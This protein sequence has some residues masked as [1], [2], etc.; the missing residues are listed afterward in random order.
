MADYCMKQKVHTKQLIAKHETMAPFLK[1]LTDFKNKDKRDNSKQ[2]LGKMLC[3]GEW[4]PLSLDNRTNI[5][6]AAKMVTGQELSNGM[7]CSYI[8]LL[9]IDLGEGKVSAPAFS[10]P[11]KN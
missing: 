2:P 1:R 6:A 9:F 4:I 8:R 5:T 10:V 3:W 7:F 11:D